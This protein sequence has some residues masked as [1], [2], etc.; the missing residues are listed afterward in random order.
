MGFWQQ[1]RVW[2]KR[3]A[4]LTEAVLWMAG[5]GALACMDPDGAHLFSFCP[6][7]WFGF[8]FCPGCGLGH[9]ISFLLHGQW[10][11]SWQA[12]PLGGP[13]LVL[14]VGRS[15]KLVRWHFSYLKQVNQPYS[16]G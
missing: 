10:Q 6:W 1:A 13:A 14:L 15:I 11:A 3:G 8:N 2:R 7:S 9:A 16:H 4:P 5:L 12:H